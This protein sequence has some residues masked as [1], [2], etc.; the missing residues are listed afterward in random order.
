MQRI[1]EAQLELE[2]LK[3]E[4]ERLPEFIHL[5]KVAVQLKQAEDY[6]RQILNKFEATSPLLN[7]GK[8]ILFSELERL[9]EFTGA[10][11]REFKFK[12]YAHKTDYR[13]K[14]HFFGPVEATVEM[15]S[16]ESLR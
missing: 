15:V 11:K 7:Q 14:S 6:V 10:T 4:A 1:N 13:L 12:R 5:P 8:D 2:G 3:I 16:R 9:D